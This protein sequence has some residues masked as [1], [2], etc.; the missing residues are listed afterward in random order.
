MK[1]KLQKYLKKYIRNISLQ[2]Q[3]FEVLFPFSKQWVSKISPQQGTLKV[4]WLGK[5]ILLSSLSS[6][7]IKKKWVSLCVYSKANGD[8]EENG[9]HK[10]RVWSRNSIGLQ[11]TRCRVLP[12]TSKIKTFYLTFCEVN[13]HEREKRER[14]QP[15]TAQ[16]THSFG[17]PQGSEKIREISLMSKFS[18]VR[19]IFWCIDTL[20]FE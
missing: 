15:R 1:H 16:T 20:S 4:W 6:L 9:S 2:Y 12:Q 11:D 10:I 5:V 18:I 3:I 7:G 8:I 13:E 14:R 19:V 17:V